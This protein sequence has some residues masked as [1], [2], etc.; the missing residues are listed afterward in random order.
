MK[1]ISISE[2]NEK[3]G[4][5]GKSLITKNC[6]GTEVV[7]YA[8]PK[9]IENKGHF[10]CPPEQKTVTSYGYISSKR[11]DNEILNPFISVQ[12]PEPRFAPSVEISTEEVKKT[13]GIKKQKDL[14]IEM[15][16]AIRYAK[17]EHAN[18][19]KMSPTKIEING[20][21]LTEF[22]KKE[23]RLYMDTWVVGTLELALEIIENNNRRG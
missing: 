13:L 17:F 12:I 3:Y 2:F 10:G 18:F 8:R 15:K 7:V 19:D 6:D 1:L 16:R 4:V 20:D 5:V 9:E 11:Y 23:T 21:E 22:I 14:V